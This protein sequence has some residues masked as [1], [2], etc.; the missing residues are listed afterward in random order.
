MTVRA[1][2]IHN[3]LDRYEYII[4]SGSARRRAQA[5]SWSSLPS[6]PQSARIRGLLGIPS[7]RRYYNARPSHGGVVR[8]CPTMNDLK[9]DRNPQPERLLRE[10]RLPNTGPSMPSSD[11]PFPNCKA[12]QIHEKNRRNDTKLQQSPIV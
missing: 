4:S 6:R 7:E 10:Y 3:R 1:A 9:R 11:V 8:L 12:V 5:P 2:A